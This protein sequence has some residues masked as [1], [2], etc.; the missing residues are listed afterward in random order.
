MAKNITD[1]QI[2][3][4]VRRKFMEV[5][6]EIDEVYELHSDWNPKK[7]WHDTLNRLRTKQY[8]IQE[9]LGEDE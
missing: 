2:A 9:I 1:K 4:N 7:D 3:D 8:L 5:N 6:K